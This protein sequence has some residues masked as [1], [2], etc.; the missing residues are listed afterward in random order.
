MRPCALAATSPTMSIWASRPAPKARPRA[1]STSTSPRTSRREARSAPRIPASAS[2]T[3]RTI[4]AAAGPGRAPRS[5]AEQEVADGDA[6]PRLAVHLVADLG[7]HLGR[8]LRLGEVGGLDVALAGHRNDQVR[9][10]LGVLLVVERDQLDAECGA[11]VRFLFQQVS[12][13]VDDAVL[14]DEQQAEIAAGRGG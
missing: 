11:A 5:L 4:E 1:P 3:R 13:V 9:R 8:E 6:R 14:A 2:S 10:G 7:Q 12:E